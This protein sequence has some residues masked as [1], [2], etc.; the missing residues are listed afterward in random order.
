MPHKFRKYTYISK[1]KKYLPSVFKQTEEQ[2]IFILYPHF[3]MI[4]DHFI[5]VYL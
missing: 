4:R 1:K 3:T 2:Y 5:P